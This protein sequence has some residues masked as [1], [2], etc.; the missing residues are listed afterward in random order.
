MIAKRVVFKGR[1]QNVGFRYAV[2]DLARSFDVCGWVMNLPDGDVEMQ[3]MGETAEVTAFIKEIT[4][5]SNV[6]HHIRSLMTET[7]PPLTG[8]RGFK[9]IR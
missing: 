1:V 8:V 2:K 4:E 6:A 5:E 9:I 3:V 7:I